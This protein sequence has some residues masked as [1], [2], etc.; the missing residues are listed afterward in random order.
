MLFALSAFSMASFCLFYWFLDA[1]SAPVLTSDLL[2]STNSDLSSGGF[3]M[4]TIFSRKIRL[5]VIFCATLLAVSASALF[6]AQTQSVAFNQAGQAGQ[7]SQANQAGA[8]TEATLKTL[9]FRAIGPAIM[10][11]RIDDFA[12]V[13]SN[14]STIFAATASSGL[15]RTTNNGTTWE[16]IFDNESHSSI[17]DVAIVQSNPDV[18]WVG[19]GEPNNR[20]SSSWGNGVYKS[21]DG[22]K[23]WANVGL[24]DSHHIGRIVIDPKNADIVYVAALG[25]LWGAN[26]E[27]GLFKTTDGGK[28]W[29]NT[30]FINE[31]TGFT[32]V[33]MDPEDSNTVYAAERLPV[34][35]AAAPAVGCIKQLMAA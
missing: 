15:W 28:T 30:K 16:P 21:T 20:Q 17:G 29:T 7:A 27:R 3:S 24:K 2:L 5:A 26:K 9:Q 32:D 11:G 14:P 13:E 18:I 22:G 23:T 1:F 25:H 8:I 19:T 4:K 31:D 10:G 34:L 33:M 12:V 6:N 35:T